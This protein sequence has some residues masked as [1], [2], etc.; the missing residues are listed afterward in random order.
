MRSGMDDSNQPTTTTISTIAI[1]AGKKATIVVALLKSVGYACLRIDEMQPRMLELGENVEETDAL[2]ATHEDLMHR[3]K[4]FISKEDQVEELLARADNLVIQQKEPDVHVY[5]AMAESLGTAWKELNR[6]LHMR[7]FLLT[8]T[9]RFYELAQRHEEISSKVGN[10]LRI[11]IQRP[12][13]ND[14]GNILLQI[15]QLIDELIDITASAVDSGAD[16]ITQIRVLGS[17]ADNVENVQETAQACLLIE[18]TMLK[19]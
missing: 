11:T 18:K 12:D 17:M 8:E 19:V 16:V 10:M 2:L 4:I 13:I 14:L 9:K 6:Q 15:Q 7:G 5:E 3:L 1:N